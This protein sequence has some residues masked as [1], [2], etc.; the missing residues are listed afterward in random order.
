MTETTIA[1]AVAPFL[2]AI[3]NLPAEALSMPPE[4]VLALTMGT[5]FD[6]RIRW[7]RTLQ[8]APERIGAYVKN[9]TAKKESVLNACALMELPPIGRFD[10]V[11]AHPWGFPMMASINFTNKYLFRRGS[12]FP[13]EDRMLASY[14]IDPERLRR[15]GGEQAYPYFYWLACILITLDVAAQKP[16]EIG[17]LASGR[18]PI[19]NLSSW[20]AMVAEAGIQIHHEVLLP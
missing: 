8:E 16:D 20:Y 15:A 7:A 2:A 4:V 18:E 12:V 19:H 9:E 5:P 17:I 6:L 3:N 11:N 10:A 1:E 14:Y 13:K